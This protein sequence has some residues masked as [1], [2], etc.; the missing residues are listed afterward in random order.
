MGLFEDVAGGFVSGLQ[1]KGFGGIGNEYVWAQLKPWLAKISTNG[2]LK[3]LPRA[4]TQMP[5]QIPDYDQ[6]VPVGPC[7]FV[8]LDQCLCCSRPVCLN[9]AFVDSQG[10]SICYLCAVALRQQGQRQGTPATPP[11]WEQQTPPPQPDPEA[12]AKERAWWARGVLRVQE[13]VSWEAIRKQ[14]RSL[15]AQFHPDR[16]DGDEARFKD[17]Q[18]AYDMLKKVYGEN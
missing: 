14:H 12:E 9:H 13:G 8:A 15:S 2:V 4:A 16:P 1:S 3:W 11:R 18:K 10:D 17:V 5:C 7:E 6:G